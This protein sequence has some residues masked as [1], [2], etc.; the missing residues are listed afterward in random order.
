MAGHEKGP[1]GRF[2]KKPA[3]KKK[4]KMKAKSKKRK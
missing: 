1:S 3:K 4:T 2:G